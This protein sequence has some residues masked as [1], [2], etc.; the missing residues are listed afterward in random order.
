MTGKQAVINNML[1]FGSAFCI[2]KT[3]IF[4]PDLYDYLNYETAFKTILIFMIMRY[5]CYNISFWTE[6]FG[7]KI[8]IKVLDIIPIQYFFL[9]IRKGYFKEMKEFF[10]DPNKVIKK[11]KLMPI[12]TIDPFM[13]IYRFMLTLI[14]IRLLILI[15]FMYF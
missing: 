14:E 1:Q 9:K 3:C 5:V 2:Q 12:I 15:Q 10:H 7:C 4:D 11:K 6:K 13:T 8:R